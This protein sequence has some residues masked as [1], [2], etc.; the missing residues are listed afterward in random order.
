MVRRRMMPGDIA[1]SPPNKLG[2]YWCLPQLPIAPPPLAGSHRASSELVRPDVREVPI[3]LGMVVRRDGVDLERPRRAASAKAAS[4]SIM[5]AAALKLL[6]SCLHVCVS[7]GCVSSLGSSAM[8][9]G[10][11]GTRVDTKVGRTAP[12]F[13]SRR[14]TIFF[15]P[16]SA[17]EVTMPT[18]AAFFRAVFPR[19]SAASMSAPPCAHAHALPCQV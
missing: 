2:P 17:V 18:P 6:A 11:L 15:R 8:I 9:C 10:L 1:R 16:S 14:T 7:R 5:Q 3:E 4:A 13:S 19:L 12:D